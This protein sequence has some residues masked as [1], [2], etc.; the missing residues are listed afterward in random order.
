MTGDYKEC[1]DGWEEVR[2]L[3]RG[4]GY[5]IG[6]VLLLG[7]AFLG[8]WFCTPLHK[9]KFHMLSLYVILP[10]YDGFMDGQ[11]ALETLASNGIEEFEGLYMRR[12]TE[13]QLERQQKWRLWGCFYRSSREEYYEELMDWVH[14]LES[15]EGKPLPALYSWR[16]PHRLSSQ[17]LAAINGP[18]DDA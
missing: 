14:W 7:L 4:V 16:D 12:P 1:Q 3:L 17:E 5:L 2:F 15:Y 9:F 6:L 18:H 10:V 13:A 8:W 11:S